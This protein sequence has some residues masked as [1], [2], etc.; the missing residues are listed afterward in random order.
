MDDRK[1]CDS[2]CV[3]VVH[4]AVVSHEEFA[5]HSVTAFRND[6][7]PFRHF[8]ER[9]RGVLHLLHERRRIGLGVPSNVFGASREVVS[10]RIGPYYFSSH[11]AMR[12]TAS[13]CGIVR[14]CSA[15]PSPLWIF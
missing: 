12:R 6:L 1:D 11:R 15:A 13:S 7:A 8:G 5:N 14:P 10:S 9:R 4:E 2:S 3:H